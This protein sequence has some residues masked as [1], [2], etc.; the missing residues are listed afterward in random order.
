M[1]RPP[2]VASARSAPCADRR[3]SLQ[4]VGDSRGQARRCLRAGV[5]ADFLR[6]LDE[7]DWRYRED[8]LVQAARGVV[9]I[10]LANVPHVAEA[11]HTLPR[12]A[13][14]GGDEGRLIAGVALLQ[15]ER[16]GQ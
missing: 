8:A 16:T 15:M 12:V 10:V 9:G 2:K 1:A 13:R 11:L 5:R 4:A 14:E 3:E 6:L 7:L